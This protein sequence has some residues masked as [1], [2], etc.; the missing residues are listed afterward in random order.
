MNILEY[1]LCQL[2][3]IS[4]TVFLIWLYNKVQWLVYKKNKVK[5]FE[6]F[7][8]DLEGS[9][10]IVMRIIKEEEEYENKNKLKECR[11]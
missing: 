10:K 5:S 1:V 7:V 4:I 8:K 3:G 2:I 11:K 6:Q 9:D